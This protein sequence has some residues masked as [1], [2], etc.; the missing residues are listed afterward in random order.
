MVFPPDGQFKLPLLPM[1]PT[2]DT[3][4]GEKKYKTT[5]RM[6]EARGVEEIHNTLIHKQYGLA[7]VNGGMLKPSDF[8]FLTVSI[9]LISLSFYISF[10]NKHRLISNIYNLS[11]YF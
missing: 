1:E 9:L 8:K 5:E 11:L 2:Y 3:E 4:A 7:A 10:Y 6:V